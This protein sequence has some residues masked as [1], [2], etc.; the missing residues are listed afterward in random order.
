MKILLFSFITSI[1]TENTLNLL[2]FYHVFFNTISVVGG[3]PRF[4]VNGN[5][6]IDPIG[7]YQI[8]TKFERHGKCFLKIHEN[9]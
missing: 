8:S 1:I 5:F 6:V 9:L 3:I 2:C 7:I 4:V